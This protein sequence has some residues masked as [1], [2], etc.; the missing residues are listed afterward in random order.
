[1]GSARHPLTL[2]S[3]PSALVPARHGGRRA[4]RPRPN[5]VLILADDLGD[6]DIGCNNPKTF[7]ET[8][9][10]DG[11]ATQGMRFTRA[12][13]PARSARPRAPAS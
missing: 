8:P 4:S 2:V 7:Y 9:N 10:I 1:M 11:L 13:R 6:M 3:L 5:V 12:T